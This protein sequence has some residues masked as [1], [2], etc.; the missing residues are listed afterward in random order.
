MPPK[1]AT[2]KAPKEKKTKLVVKRIPRR[3]RPTNPRPASVTNVHIHTANEKPH[4]LI[5]QQLIVHARPPPPS[6]APKP[7]PQRTS[8]RTSR[9]VAMQGITRGGAIGDVTGPA[10]MEGISRNRQAGKVPF[11]QAVY[12]LDTSRNRTT[13]VTTSMDVSS[14]S[15][16]HSHSEGSSSHLDDSPA[17]TQLYEKFGRLITKYGGAEPKNRTAV[18]D[19]TNEGGGGVQEA[20]SW[21][22]DIGEPQPSPPRPQ[23]IRRGRERGS[24]LR[25][26]DVAGLQEDYTGI[27]I[28]DPLD[29]VLGKRKRP[30]D[31]NPRKKAKHQE[32]HFPIELRDVEIPPMPL[33]KRDGIPIVPNRRNQPAF[34]EPIIFTRPRTAEVLQLNNE[35]FYEEQRNQA[36]PMQD[37]TEPSPNPDQLP[38]HHINV[39]DPVVATRLE[40]LDE[41]ERYYNGPRRRAPGRRVAGV[42]P[43]IERVHRSQYHSFDYGGPA[44]Y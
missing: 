11:T 12:P 36:A 27:D 2:K 6:A 43:R 19:L 3:R 26:L 22:P 14:S 35:L 5:P 7:A 9:P 38:S 40:A 20:K 44:P 32:P 34:A 31:N 30:E 21:N 18:V 23:H 13:P 41:M 37:E 28:K 24:Q 42:I 1:K 39:F 4:Q 16:S 29:M 25:P 10:P 33:G 15:S 8:R 17:M